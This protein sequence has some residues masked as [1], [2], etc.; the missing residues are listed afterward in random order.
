MNNQ[1]YQLQE[2]LQYVSELFGFGKKIEDPVFGKMKKTEGGSGYEGSYITTKPIFKDAKVV[3]Y[4]SEPQEFYK[5]YE[6][7]KKNYSKIYQ[8][9]VKQM[10]LYC[11]RFKKQKPTEDNEGYRNATISDIN[12][13]PLYLIQ[14]QNI[15]KVKTAMTLIFGT[16]EKIDVEHDLQCS[17]DKNGK[18]VEVQN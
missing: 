7:M 15:S 18:F 8:K 14:F 9:C 3:I 16:P 2:S 17:F 11:Q 4:G 6:Y 13:F 12:S 5:L 10:F 1:Y